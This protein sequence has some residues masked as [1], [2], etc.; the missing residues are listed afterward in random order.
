VAAP[1][2]FIGV[3]SHEGSRYSASQGPSGLAAV[4]STSLMEAGVATEVVVDTSNRLDTSLNPVS[5]EDVQDAL[6]AQVRLEDE[7]NVYLSGTRLSGMK[8]AVDSTLRWGRRL[9]RKVAPPS[10]SMVERLLNIEMAHVALLN[11][12][13]SSGAP[14]ILILEDDASADDLADLSIGLVQLLNAAPDGVQFINV[15][16]SFDVLELGIDHLLSDTDVEWAG[17]VNRRVASASRPVT[18]TVCAIA[19]RASFA[20]ELLRE[21][22]SM[23]VRPVVPIDWKLNKALMSMHAS[24]EVGADSCWWVVPGPIDQLSMRG[25]S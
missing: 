9:W 17:S 6:S 13:L 25:D 20:A 7:W 12:G 1:F 11:L 4:L 14:W 8:A 15:S 16:E 3:V 21:F 24:G 2:L 18:N 23:P 22:S 5:S 10:T 19:Y